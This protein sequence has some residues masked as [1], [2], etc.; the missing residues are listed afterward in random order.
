MTIRRIE[1]QNRVTDDV[2]PI[3]APEGWPANQPPEHNPFGLTEAAKVKLKTLA[4][5]IID[6]EERAKE[7]AEE[8]RAFFKEAKSAGY[9]PAALRQ[10]IAYLKNEADKSEAEQLRDLYVE[11]LRE[12]E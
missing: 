10:A 4:A 8:K 7:V 9:D 12:R 5:N 11:A 2:D 6:C 3:V 1:P